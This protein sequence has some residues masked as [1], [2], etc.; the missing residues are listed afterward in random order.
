MKYFWT[1]ELCPRGPGQMK[2][3]SS[4]HVDH[5]Q[6]RCACCANG[7]TCSIREPLCCDYTPQRA[8]SSDARKSLPFRRVNTVAH[9]DDS[10]DDG[11]G[12]SSGIDKTAAGR[13]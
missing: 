4:V 2:M 8:A 5:L 9:D 10:D 13:G 3:S 12:G 6:E 7:R 1:A 11:G